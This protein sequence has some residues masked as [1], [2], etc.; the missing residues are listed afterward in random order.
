MKCVQNKKDKAIT[1]VTDVEAFRL[2]KQVKSHI[3]I[4]K[5]EWKESKRALGGK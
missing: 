1:R 2:V 4:P 5:K 3:Y